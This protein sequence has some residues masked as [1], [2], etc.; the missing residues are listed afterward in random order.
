MIHN[1]LLKFALNRHATH[2]LIKFIK[3]AEVH[4]FLE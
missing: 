2:V 4:P 1:D 3:T